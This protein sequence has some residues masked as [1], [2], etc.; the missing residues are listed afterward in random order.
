MRE[1]LPQRRYAEGFDLAFPRFTDKFYTVTIGCHPDGRLAEVFINAHT[2]V[3][4]DGDLAARDVAILISMSL[5][6]G[7]TVEGLA[8]AMTHDASGKP[9]GLAGIVLAELVKWQAL[10]RVERA[11]V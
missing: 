6:H 3:G 9:E 2:K 10:N 7:A 11:D 5:Q 1:A 4:S 8:H